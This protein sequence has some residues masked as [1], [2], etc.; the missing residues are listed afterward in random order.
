MAD[1]EVTLGAKNEASEVLRQFQQD[2]QNAGQNIQF[3]LRGLGQLAGL[4]A[5]V[6]GVVEGAKAIA[7]FATSSV[8]AFDEVNKSAIRLNETLAV[9][10][11]AA[12]VSGDQLSRLAEQLERVTNVDQSQIVNQMTAA[13]RRGADPGQLD[14]MAEAAIG[15]AR[16][17]DRDLGS[18]MRLV[19]Q[20]TQGNFEA[21]RGLIPQI[22]ALATE[23]EKL[24]AVS[25]LAQTGL[26]NKAQ[27]ARSALESSE[28]LHVATKQL[29]QTV[30]ALVVPFRDAVYKGMVLISDFINGQLNPDFDTFEQTIQRFKDSVSNVAME[31]AEAFVTGFTIAE[32][33]V[34]NFSDSL[35]VMVDGITLLIVSMSQEIPFRFQEM[36]IQMSWLVENIGAITAVVAMGK[37]TFAEAFQDMPTLGQREITKLEESLANSINERSIGLVDEFARTL[38]ERIAGLRREF[39]VPFDVN[40]ARNQRPQAGTGLQNQL[41]DLQAFESRILTRGPAQSPVDKIAENTAKMVE[42]QRDTTRAI[43]GLDVSPS[44][45]VNLEEIR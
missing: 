20:A 11:N 25:K 32:F 31:V 9:L 42:A 36:A 14:E 40:L 3:S 38:N 5:V 43:E 10:P 1:L 2:F 21:F 12:G 16:V 28:A 30:G 44:T 35:R 4:T 34:K 24:A 27:A 13:A 29:Y 41:R 23:E 45:N 33:A 15:L 8:T 37:T 7:N 18:A 22:D 6:V 17:F 26:E 39:Q 19:E